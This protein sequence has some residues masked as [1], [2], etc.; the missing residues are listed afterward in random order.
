M[1]I[2]GRPGAAATLVYKKAGAFTGPTITGCAVSS[3]KK[4][5]VIKFNT[6]L[7]AT[8]SIEVQDCKSKQCYA[9]LDQ[10]QQLE[11]ETRARVVG[12][13][14]QHVTTKHRITRWIR[15]TR[16]APRGGLL[17]DKCLRVE[18]CRHQLEHVADE[19]AARR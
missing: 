5:I 9:F 16:Y 17:T 18:Y 12:A 2:L 4:S 8:D 6:S 1:M 10:P 15:N 3:D 19:R 13:P 7:L 14:L 11:I